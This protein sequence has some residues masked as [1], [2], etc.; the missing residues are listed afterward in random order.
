MYR[1]FLAEEGYAPK[2]DDEGDVVFKFEGGNYLIMVDENDDEFFRLVYPGFWEV[3][4][5][6]ERA[7]ITQ[8]ALHATGSTKVAKFFI[9][10]DNT[11]GV[12]ELFCAPP[13]AFKTVF[14]R[15]MNA[16][17]AGVQVFKEKMHE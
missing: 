8:A 1:A 4:D 3:E 13:E 11:W 6:A 9:V 16:L 15:S 2:M 10:R 17:R 7:K 5:D 12:L 14:H